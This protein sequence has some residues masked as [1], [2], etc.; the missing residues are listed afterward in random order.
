M[1]PFQVFF[2]LGQKSAR[3]AS[4]CPQL[5]DFPVSIRVRAATGP[6]R[7][8]I[9]RANLTKSLR[10]RGTLRGQALSMLGNRPR[11]G[12]EFANA[13]AA[14]RLFVVN[15]WMVADVPRRASR[16]G[17]ACAEPVEAPRSDG[18]SLAG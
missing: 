17:I 2:T 13:G 15:S 4:P 10:T 8:R 11:I 18:S 12:N 9:T 3:E 7:D 5:D 16:T 6:A 1:R 14:I